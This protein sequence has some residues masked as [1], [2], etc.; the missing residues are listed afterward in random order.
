MNQGEFHSSVLGRLLFRAASLPNVPF[1][2]KVP[3]QICWGEAVS[4][5]NLALWEGRV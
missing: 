5:A 2:L 4:R 1:R 3:W